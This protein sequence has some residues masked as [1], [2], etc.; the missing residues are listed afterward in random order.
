MKKIM[1]TLDV[2][3]IKNF[4][5]TGNEKTSHIQ[6]ELFAKHT[7]DKELYPKYTKNFKTQQEVNKTH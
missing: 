1:D 7:S 3:K 6:G 4:Y 2:I 5:V